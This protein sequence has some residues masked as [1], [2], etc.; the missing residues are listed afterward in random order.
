ME[1]RIDAIFASRSG[2]RETKDSDSQTN[3]EEAGGVEDFKT[4]LQVPGQSSTGCTHAGKIG[5]PFA[6]NADRQVTSRL[7]ERKVGW[8]SRQSTSHHSDPAIP[9]SN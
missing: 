4:A 8:H 9:S 3:H 5:I 1:I 6:G 7:L 2:E